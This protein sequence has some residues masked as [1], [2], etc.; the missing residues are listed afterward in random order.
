[1]S[2]QQSDGAPVS[3]RNEVTI[4][5]AA[6]MPKVAQPRGEQGA[7]TA[8]GAQHAQQA[9]NGRATP[10]Q[11]HRI[12]KTFINHGPPAIGM[13]EYERPEDVLARMR[14]AVGDAWGRDTDVALQGED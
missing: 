10:A 7:P 9:R 8:D 6:A 11:Q 4:A 2:A 12:I 14:A 3:P 1:M 13:L 5:H